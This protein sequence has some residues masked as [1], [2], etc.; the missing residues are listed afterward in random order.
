MSG[1]KYKVVKPWRFVQA[2]FTAT[3]YDPSVQSTEALYS[4]PCSM[5]RLSQSVIIVRQLCGLGF[6][7]GCTMSFQMLCVLI[8]FWM[9]DLKELEF[10]PLYGDKPVNSDT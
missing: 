4:V 6:G 2:P 9:G 7:V 1:R 5:N 10:E 8:I 3:A